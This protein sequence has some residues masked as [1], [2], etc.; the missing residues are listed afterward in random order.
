MLPN[1][2][3]LKVN[4][5]IFSDCS[6]GALEGAEALFRAKMRDIANIRVAIPVEDATNAA[7]PTNA[8]L[9]MASLSGLYADVT[10]TAAR[11]SVPDSSASSLDAV[12]AF[13]VV[14]VVSIEA[15]LEVCIAFASRTSR[16]TPRVTLEIGR[17]SA[18][19]LPDLYLSKL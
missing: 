3:L 13:E 18:G 5:L 7:K 6:V 8:I 10:L 12:P 16:A 19:T 9:L 11:V 4:G 2:L 15:P 17:G 1:R 14:L